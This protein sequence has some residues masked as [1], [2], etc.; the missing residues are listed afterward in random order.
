VAASSHFRGAFESICGADP[1]PAASH[2]IPDPEPRQDSRASVLQ[3]AW[4]T[5]G[6]RARQVTLPSVS[7]AGRWIG[8]RCCAGRAICPHRSGTK[9]R[10]GDPQTSHGHIWNPAPPR[11]RS[12]GAAAESTLP[13]KGGQLDDVANLLE[14]ICGRCGAT[15]DAVANS[16][17]FSPPS[18]WT[19]G[20]ADFYENQPWQRRPQLLAI[21]TACIGQD[22]LDEQTWRG[23][24]APHVPPAY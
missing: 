1:A 16:D 2:R 9:Y 17:E 21:A 4:L 3:A 5:A 10:P 6:T 7:G 24:P 18:A 8:A 22:V 20:N 12:T 11:F 14:A 19:I 13:I 15:V 23:R